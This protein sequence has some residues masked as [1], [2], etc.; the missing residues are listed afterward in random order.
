MHYV[1]V[2]VYTC[3]VR[4]RSW[5]YKLELVRIGSIGCMWTAI[6]RYVYVYASYIY[7]YV[8]MH[9]ERCQPIYIYIYIY[10]Y[11]YIHTYIHWQMPLK[12][13][14]HNMGSAQPLEYLTFVKPDE[15]FVTWNHAWWVC[16]CADVCMSVCLCVCVC[17]CVCVYI[18][19]YI[20]IY[21]YK[22]LCWT[23]RELCILKPCLAVMHVCMCMCVCIYIY[24]YIYI[25]AYIHVHKCV[26]S[27]FVKWNHD[28]ATRNQTWT[29][30]IYV[31]MYLH[32]YSPET[33][34]CAVEVYLSV[35]V[36]RIHTC[37]TYVSWKYICLI[38]IC[39]TYTYMQNIRIYI[40][41]YIGTRLCLH[42]L[43][44]CEWTSAAA[45]MTSGELCVCVCIYICVCVCIYICVC[46]CITYAHTCKKAISSGEDDIRWAVCVCAY[47]HIYICV[48]V[49]VS[50][51]HTQV[52][53][54]QQ[55]RRWH[56]VSYVC[57]CA[58][59]CVCVC[60]YH[61]CTPM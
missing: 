17:M 38:L 19:I 29:P 30:Y 8:Y 28:S 3:I 20:Y 61:V 10:I 13:Y 14:C 21:I 22:H 44:R 54:H 27:P 39:F 16:M 7:T 26:K 11:T 36:T 59:M 35:C 45:K 51:M 55:R 23:I 18:Y 37:K 42:A 4:A 6:L 49:C 53:G 47:I 34:V 5:I 24:I 48:C 1:H 58:Y 32:T 52:K 50:R 15:N 40:Y 46:V 25:Y 41:L 9:R 60:V 57:V 31:H 43:R 12:I 56:Q 2:C 33:R